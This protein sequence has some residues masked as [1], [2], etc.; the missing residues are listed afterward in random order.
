MVI[1]VEKS[2]SRRTLLERVNAIFKFIARQDDVFP[3]SRLKEIGLNPK[4]AEQWL[5][6]I[7]YIQSQPKIRIVQTEHNTLIEKVEGEYQALMRKMILDDSIPF[8][9]RLQHITDYMKSL[10]ARER[11]KISKAGI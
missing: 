6:L 5:K 7:S 11:I 3:K 1:M 8:E 9:Q 2:S 10:Y 4:T